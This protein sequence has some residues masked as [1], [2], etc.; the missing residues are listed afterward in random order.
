MRCAM[1]IM[2]FFQRCG[3]SAANSR[4]WDEKVL[5]FSVDVNNSR[6]LK[7][8]MEMFRYYL[9]LY[10]EACFDFEI[11][12]ILSK[13]SHFPFNT[14]FIRLWH[15]YEFFVVFWQVCDLAFACA[16]LDI[17]TYLGTT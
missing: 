11:I 17:G 2:M 14:C 12:L 6:V 4:V 16:I 9:D 3:R 1:E 15:L 8:I 10:I 13:R 5:E 7:D